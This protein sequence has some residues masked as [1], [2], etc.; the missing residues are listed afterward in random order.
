MWKS[1]C[2]VGDNHW[3]E[4]AIEAGSCCAVTN[5]LYIKE[6][7]LSICSVDFIF[8][9]KEGRGRIVGSFPEQLVELCV[10]CGELLD[11]MAIHLILLVANKV[12]PDLIGSIEIHSDCTGALC[13][14]STLPKNRIPKK[15]CHSDIL[16][17]VMVICVNLTFTVSYHHIRS[18]QD[19]HEQ[20]VKLLHSSQLNCIADLHAKWVI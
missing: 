1:L 17:N 2:L 14:I 6:H 12:L 13:Q 11:L 16:K 9:C 15:C 19:N 8:E 4:E 3:L 10:Y 7:F 20:Y 18:H 5:G